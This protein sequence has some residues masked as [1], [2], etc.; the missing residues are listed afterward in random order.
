[1]RKYGLISLYPFGKIPRI[2]A[3]ATAGTTKQSSPLFQLA[4]VA[5]L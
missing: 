2:S 1:M 5:T 4:G 3:V